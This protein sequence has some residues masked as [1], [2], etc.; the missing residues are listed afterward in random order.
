MIDSDMIRRIALTVRL[1]L[2]SDVEPIKLRDDFLNSCRAA[3]DRYL[4]VLDA[5][6]H[7]ANATPASLARI[8]EEGGSVWKV[9]EDGKGLERR[10]D[11]VATEAFTQATTPEDLA[12]SELRQAWSRAFGRDSDASDAWDHAIKAVEAILAP[13]VVPAQDKPQIG[14]VLGQLRSQGDRWRLVVPGPDQ[15][16]DVSPLVTMLKTIWP[17]PDRHAAGNHRTPSLAEAQAVLHLA[18]TIV[19]WAR[20]GAIARA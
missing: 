5:I 9:R 12:S 17:N 20:S 13:I 1:P 10:V 11:P 6:L 8:L 14:H 15:D 16:H 3:D 4:D 19:Q 7:L 2:R 18:V